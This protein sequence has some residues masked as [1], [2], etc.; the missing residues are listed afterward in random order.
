M[1]TNIRIE[2]VV[3]DG[4]KLTRAERA[5]LAPA[6]AAELRRLAGE[7]AGEPAGRRAGPQQAGQG[8]SVEGIAREVAAAVHRALRP[9]VVARPAAAPTAS[10]APMLPAAPAAL[11]A[12]VALAAPEALAA[13]R[14]HR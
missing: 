8:P 10:A 1:S 4:L 13:P 14:G 2:R 6:I 7:P 12:P 5:A 11:A 9:A 3:L